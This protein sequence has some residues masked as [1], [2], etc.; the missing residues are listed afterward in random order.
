VRSMGC[1]CVCVYN[2]YYNIEGQI[3]N[4]KNYQSVPFLADIYIICFAC[5]LFY[6]YYI[7]YRNANNEAVASKALLAMA[8]Q[9]KNARRVRRVHL[10]HVNGSTGNRLTFHPPTQQ[11]STRLA[12]QVRVARRVNRQE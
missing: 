6:I 10:L 1:V 5:I 11:Y 4:R 3:E 8:W 9:G 12:G 7:F 2:V